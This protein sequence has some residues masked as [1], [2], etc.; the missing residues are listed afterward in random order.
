MAANLEMTRLLPGSPAAG[1]VC[2]NLLHLVLI[3]HCAVAAVDAGPPAY[4]LPQS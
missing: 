1:A 4:D 3:K 2:L